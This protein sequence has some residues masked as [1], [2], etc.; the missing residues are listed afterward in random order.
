M[1]AGTV[2][3]ILSYWMELQTRPCWGNRGATHQR[4]H[5]RVIFERHE[6]LPMASGS[7]ALSGAMNAAD[8]EVKVGSIALIGV[9]IEQ[10]LWA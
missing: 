2:P 5:I 4:A 6:S 1:L 10:A 9:T 3:Y 7:V 8:P